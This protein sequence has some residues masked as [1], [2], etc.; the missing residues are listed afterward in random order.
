MLSITGDLWILESPFP[1]LLAAGDFLSFTVVFLNGSSDSSVDFTYTVSVRKV[2][3]KGPNQDGEIIKSYHINT[4][5][6]PKECYF[7]YPIFFFDEAGDYWLETI[8][9]EGGIAGR[10]IQVFENYEY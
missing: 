1:N 8:Y 6:G 7:L 5:L 4:T 9:N 3:Q 10:S 2:A